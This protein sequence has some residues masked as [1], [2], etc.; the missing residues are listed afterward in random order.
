LSAHPEVKVSRL[1]KYLAAHFDHEKSSMIF[2]KEFFQQQK[3]NV[4]IPLINT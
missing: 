1:E 3:Q 4:A 2:S